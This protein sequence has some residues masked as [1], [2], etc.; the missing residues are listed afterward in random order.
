M[1]MKN[2]PTKPIVVDVRPNGHPSFGTL[3]KLGP[4]DY[5]I[6]QE[7]YGFQTLYT[8]GHDKVNPGQYY[9]ALWGIELKPGP[10]ILQPQTKD[11]NGNPAANVLVWNSWPG[12]ETI[13][14][15]ADPKYKP[16]GVGGFTDGG[17]SIGWAYG[18]ESWVPPHGPGGPYTVWCNAGQGELGTAYGSDALDKIG[19][20][21]D[22]ITPNPIFRF[23][24]KEGAAPPGGKYKLVNLGPDGQVLGYI[25]FVE[26]PPT[27]TERGS[28]AVT[29]NDEVVLHVPWS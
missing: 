7:F 22:H 11:V 14:P 1:E 18:P 6:L 29:Y 26:G 21:D 4:G 27:P 3:P 12:A 24:K 9:F 23:M 19:W 25:N 13:N 2:M 8:Y 28:L 17:G 20:W 15:A 10:A 5:D 16:T